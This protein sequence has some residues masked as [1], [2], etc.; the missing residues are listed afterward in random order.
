MLPILSISL[1]QV[2]SLSA[3]V[4]TYDAS[5][6]E[7]ILEGDPERAAGLVLAARL[8]D[9]AVL[10]GDQLYWLLE[11]FVDPILVPCLAGACADPIEALT[12]CVRYHPDKQM[13]TSVVLV[14]GILLEGQ[15]IPE[16][17]VRPVFRFLKKTRYTRASP[18]VAAVQLLDHWLLYST[19]SSNSDPDTHKLEPVVDDFRRCLAGDFRR[20]LIHPPN[21]E[22]VRRTSPKVGRNDPCPCGSG[23]KFKKCCQDKVVAAAYEA[24]VQPKSVNARRLPLHR[25]VQLKWEALSSPDL[26]LVVEELASRGPHELAMNGL[27]SLVTR[28]NFRD[29]A[30]DMLKVFLVQFCFRARRREIQELLKWFVSE[31]PPSPWVELMRSALTLGG[32]RWE[33]WLVKLLDKQAELADWAYCIRPFR[34][35]LSIL[36]TRA[37]FSVQTASFEWESQPGHVGR[38]PMPAQT[39]GT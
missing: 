32:K 12:R 25:L 36:F 8:E 7:A 6:A 33:G 27:K 3:Q 13:V 35:A 34:P 15:T 2:H 37:S 23:A 21:F 4:A 24:W 10:D 39:R 30:E 5:L 1:H 22:P 19:S 31:F 17:V 26:E 11:R 29:D 38:G 9:K 28:P 20:H 16:S 14:L 18:L